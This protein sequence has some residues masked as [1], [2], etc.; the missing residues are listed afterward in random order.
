MTFDD[1]NDLLAGKNL[2][3]NPSELHGVL[4]G[5]IATGERLSDPDLDKLLMELLDV[6]LDLFDELEQTLHALYGHCLS[7]IQFQGFEF[8]PLL[9]DDEFPL[10]ERTDA[11]GEWCQGFLFGLSAAGADLASV[12]VQDVEEVLTDLASFAKLRGEDADEDDESNFMELV[13]YVR[14]AVLL[15]HVHLDVIGPESRPVLH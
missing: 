11:L 13:E 8:S 4:C 3:V 10:P 1:L 14:V 12:D 2:L 15:I 9:P 6:E 5:R 7:Q